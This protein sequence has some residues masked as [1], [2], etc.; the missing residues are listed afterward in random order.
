M[1]LAAQ[2]KKPVA[3]P[4]FMSLAAGGEGDLTVETINRDG[5]LNLMTG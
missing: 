4:Q 2:E 5:S 1:R 3:S